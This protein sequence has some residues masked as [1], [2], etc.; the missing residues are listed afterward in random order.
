M[1]FIVNVLFVKVF[2]LRSRNDVFP[3]EAIAG[4]VVAVFDAIDVHVRTV[5]PGIVDDATKTVEAVIDVPRLGIAAAGCADQCVS[6][7][8]C[9]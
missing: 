6:D 3:P 7:V 1:N 8:G 5:D 4:S 9:A 2:T